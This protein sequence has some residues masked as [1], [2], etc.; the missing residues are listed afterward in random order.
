MCETASC[1]SL[2]AVAQNIS[3]KM[4]FKSKNP[5]RDQYLWTN[6]FAQTLGKGRPGGQQRATTETVP[7][8]AQSA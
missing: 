5:K 3:F 6:A 2:K 8:P 7:I 4:L 1:L